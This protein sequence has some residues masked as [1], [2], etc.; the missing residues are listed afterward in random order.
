M[1]ALTEYSKFLIGL[2]AIVDPLGA[3]A[4]LVGLTASRTHD[5]R[6]L[7]ARHTV[8]WVFVILSLSLLAGK[9]LLLLFGIS[10]HSF[11]VAGGLLLLLMGIQMLMAGNERP[12]NGELDTALALVPMSMPLLAGP[13]AI[14][15]VIVYAHRGEGPAHIAMVWLVIA[16]VCLTLALVFRLLPWFM[17]HLTPA[18][19][20][21]STRLMGVLLASIAVEFIANGLRGLFPV[22]AG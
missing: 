21:V 4:M 14:S 12:G 17:R 22:L 1:L 3:V 6:R 13:G 15:A 18:R 11:R 7:I 20:N 19:V 9:Y 16:V 5:V 8:L 2:L 10:I